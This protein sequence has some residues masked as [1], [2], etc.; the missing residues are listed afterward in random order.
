MGAGPERRIQQELYGLRGYSGNRTR[1]RMQMKNIIVAVAGTEGNREYKDVQ[2][3]PGTK[4]RDVLAK[5]E[6]F[7]QTVAKGL[8]KLTFEE[9]QV[10]LR[11]LVENVV[12]ENDKVRV[13]TIITLK[14][15]PEPVALRPLC[16]HPRAGQ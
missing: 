13:D 6:T 10:L 5:L 16:L 2:L 14:E 12:I 8:D 7:C 15:G 3:L 4:A 11:L 9:K 1:R